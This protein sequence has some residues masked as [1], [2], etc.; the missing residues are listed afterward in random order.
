MM[1]QYVEA[2]GA[3]IFIFI[4]PNKNSLYGQYMPEL[5]QNFHNKAMQKN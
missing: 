1:Q 5:E 2:Q 4:A 3:K